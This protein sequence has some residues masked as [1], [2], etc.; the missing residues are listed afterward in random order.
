M[1]HE[2]LNCNE[3][4]NLAAAASGSGQVVGPD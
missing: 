4:E 2:Y 1:L 3:L